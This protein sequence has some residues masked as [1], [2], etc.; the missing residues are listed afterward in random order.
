M[1]NK[2]K[3]KKHKHNR[4]ILELKMLYVPLQSQ[5]SCSYRLIKGKTVQQLRETKAG[6]EAKLLATKGI[7]KSIVMCI[8]LLLT[9]GIRSTHNMRFLHLRLR[10]KV[11]AQVNGGTLKMSG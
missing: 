5:K 2:L 7:P 9:E 4:K 6:Q 1:S 11:T 3:G 8:I 10:M